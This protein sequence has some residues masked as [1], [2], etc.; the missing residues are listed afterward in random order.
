MIERLWKETWDETLATELDLERSGDYKPED[1]YVSGRRSKDW[2]DK[3]SPDWWAHHGPKFVQSWV[4][5]RDA[6]G[7][8]IWTTPTGEPAIE[9]EVL[10]NRGSYEVLSVIDRVMIDED[11]NLY[12]L[13]LKSGSHTPAWPRQLALNNLGLNQQF[14]VRARYGGFWNARKGGVEPMFD[15]EQYDEEW[16]WGQVQMARKIRDQQL[17]VAQPTNLCNSACSVREYC[18]A[19][20]GALSLTVDQPVFFSE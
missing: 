16:M 11:G 13:D 4:N 14:G 3:E 20:G 1:F 17:F 15:L 7:L 18:K 12:I 5:W 6:S 9:L 19:M 10:A 8:D 2:P